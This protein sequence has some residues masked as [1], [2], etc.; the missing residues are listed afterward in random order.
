MDVQ[1]AE[2]MV[3]VRRY[4]E[5]VERARSAVELD[6]AHWAGWGVLGINRLRLGDIEEGR[7]D[8]ER[9]FGGDP[10]NPW[11]KNT[12]DLLDT[13][14][15]FDVRRTEHFH[16]ALHGTES[17]ILAAYLEPLAEEAFSR[18]AELY[19]GEPEGPVRAELFPS[20]A[21]FSVRT[22]GEP[23]LGALGV[24]FGPVLVMDS[25]G[26]RTRGEYNWASVFWH[27]LA[28]TFHLSLSD[29]R[30]PRWFSE[31]LAVHE[32]R[33]ARAGW[34]P[35]VSFAF[36]QAFQDGRL[37]KVSTLNDGFMRPDEPQQVGFSY[38]QASLV[39]EMIEQRHGF[40][41]IRQ[42]LDGYRR[43]EDTASLVE[44]LRG[45]AMDALDEDFDAYLRAKYAT[46]LTGLVSTSEPPAPGASTEE[47]E[48]FVRTHPGDLLGRLRLAA[49]L[50]REERFDDAEPHFREALRIFPEYGGPDA[51]YWFLAKIHERRGET[52]QAAAALRRLTER[53]ESNYDALLL[54]ADLEEQL[55]RTAESAA[56]LEQAVHVWPYERSVHERLADLYA[57]TSELDG[58][59]RERRAVVALDPPDRAEAL[60]RLALAEQT[61][62]D[63]TAARRSVML[64]LDIAPNYEEALELLL[65]LR[66]GGVRP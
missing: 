4:R 18:L 26:A 20:H 49:T 19:Q 44:S 66:S 17:E 56:A 11:F 45:M 55:G 9:A 28:H 40:D 27:E 12:L 42:M 47:L 8:V 32:Q 39:F 63:T 24:S 14:E 57:T 36:L 22:L 43:G 48:R 61:A 5:A 51:P 46:A 23:G 38:Y 29:H 25:P 59:V 31:G 37:E 60:Y 64:A 16:L 34:G 15:R 65:T 33:R 10:F 62:G 41:V 35:G 2:V 30:V 1:L 58:A 54:L 3:Q 21:D 50:Y 6:S 13:F 7:A 53:S 52:G